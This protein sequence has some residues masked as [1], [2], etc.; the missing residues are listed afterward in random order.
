MVNNQVRSNVNIPDSGTALVQVDVS[1]LP[2]GIFFLRAYGLDSAGNESEF[3]EALRLTKD[4]VGPLV[5]EKAL[6]FVLVPALDKPQIALFVPGTDAVV[7]G[8]QSGWTILGSAQEPISI[9]LQD[10][11]GNET[12]IKNISFVPQF[13]GDSAPEIRLPSHVQQFSRRLSAALAA[14]LVILLLLSIFIRIRVQRPGLIAH[15]S[16]VIALAFFLFLL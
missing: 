3:S 12:V 4:T 11:F 9:T 13:S 6:A 10:Q 14:V 5:D 8:Q 15:A 7:N 2:E 16:A 1:S